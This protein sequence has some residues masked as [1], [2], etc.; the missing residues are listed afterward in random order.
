MGPMALFG[1]PLLESLRTGVFRILGYTLRRAKMRKLALVI[2]FGFFKNIS[3]TVTCRVIVGQG[4]CGYNAVEHCEA[5]GLHPNL[6]CSRLSVSADDREAGGR[7]AG[8]GREK[9]RG[10]CPH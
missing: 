10:D 7:R 5:S 3:R 9:K 8:Y 2:S 1:R 6:A 4:P